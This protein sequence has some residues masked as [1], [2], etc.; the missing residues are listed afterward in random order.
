MRASIHWPKIG[1]VVV[2]SA[3]ACREFLISKNASAADMAPLSLTCCP[4]IE[5]LNA[6]M[7]G[8]IACGTFRTLGWLLTWLTLDNIWVA[9]LVDQEI[10]HLSSG[11]YPP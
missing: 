8:I 5:K 2:V 11:M 9:Y 4:P 7:S 3:F 6:W 10:D 1:V